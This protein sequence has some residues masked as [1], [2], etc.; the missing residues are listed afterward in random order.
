[1]HELCQRQLPAS[2]KQDRGNSVSHSVLKDVVHSNTD[3]GDWFR[4]KASGDSLLVLIHSLRLCTSPAWKYSRPPPYDT[5]IVYSCRLI[6]CRSFAISN[7]S[8]ISASIAVT[9]LMFYTTQILS[10]YGRITKIE[11]FTIFPHSK[12][13]YNLYLPELTAQSGGGS[14]TTRRR[15]RETRTLL[16]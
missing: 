9:G 5:R 2:F 13:G 14:R 11:C 12:S 3:R 4:T 10:V 7:L 6:C 16:L 15:Y 1:M 8:R